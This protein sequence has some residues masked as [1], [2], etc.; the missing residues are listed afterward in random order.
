MADQ[1]T[2]CW[3]ALD[4]TDP[5]LPQA[6]RLYEATQAP[7]ERIPWKWIEGAVAGR[8]AWRPGQWAPHLLL[9][10]DRASPRP[11]TGFAYGIHLP[12]YGGYATYLGVE[13][14]QRG[15]GVGT[16]LLRLLTRVLQVDAECEGV[17]LPFVVWESHRPDESAPAA[18]WDLWRAR[19]RLF[20]RAGASWVSGLDFWAPNF[21]RRGGAPVPL[22]LFLLPVGTPAEAFDAAALRA[23]AAGLLGEVYG[24]GPGDPLFERTLPPDCRPS[25]RPVPEALGQAAAAGQSAGD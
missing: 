9:A 14:R 25:L 21:A 19:L 12:G 6:R 24:R 10:A 4:P 16:R 1:D 20:G 3:E 7:A 5:A 13:P 2:L 15:R 22:Q 18:E 23:V 8:A 11:V 17:P